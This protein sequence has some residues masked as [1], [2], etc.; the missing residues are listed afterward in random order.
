MSGNRVCL[1]LDVSNKDYI[2]TWVEENKSIAS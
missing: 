1:S 2:L